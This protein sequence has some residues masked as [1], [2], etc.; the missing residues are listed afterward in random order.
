VLYIQRSFDASGVQSIV[1]GMIGGRGWEDSATEE[2]LGDARHGMR[3][4]SERN[5]I[6]A[7]RL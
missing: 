4:G 5:G 1:R 6:R 3:G 2:S 7:D